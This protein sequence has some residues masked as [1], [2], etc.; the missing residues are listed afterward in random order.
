MTLTIDIDLA[1]IGVFIG[2]AKSNQILSFV[3]DI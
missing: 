2:K 1:L 3:I